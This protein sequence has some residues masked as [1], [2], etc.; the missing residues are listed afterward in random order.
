MT[1]KWELTVAQ[2]VRL[3]ELA[4]VVRRKKALVKY[5]RDQLKRAR[6]EAKKAEDEY[7]EYV[8]WAEEENKKQSA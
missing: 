7:D 8:A 4:K 6:E 3:D 2:R 1:K 5:M